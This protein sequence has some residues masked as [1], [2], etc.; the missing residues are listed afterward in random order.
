MNPCFLQHWNPDIS[1]PVYKAGASVEVKAETPKKRKEKDQALPEVPF[2]PDKTTH[3]EVWKLIDEKY[4]HSPYQSLITSYVEGLLPKAPEG[5]REA[6]VQNSSQ[7]YMKFYEKAKVTFM[8]EAEALKEK[9]DDAVDDIKDRVSDDLKVL[10]SA[11]EGAKKQTEFTAVMPGPESKDA[12]EDHFEDYL[13]ALNARYFNVD[14]NFGTDVTEIPV[15]IVGAMVPKGLSA[16]AYRNKANEFESKMS[17]WVEAKLEWMLKSKKTTKQDLDEFK[18]EIED[19]YKSYSNFDKNSA[20]ISGADLVALD[21]LAHPGLDDV[22]LVLDES[23]EG[24]I[25]RLKI[26]QLMN[27]DGWEETVDMA[28]D[29]TLKGVLN[30]HSETKFIE[31]MKQ[32]GEVK[33]FGDAADLFEDRLE[34]LGKADVGATLEFIRHFNQEVHGD[35]LQYEAAVEPPALTMQV[36]KQMDY[37]LGGALVPQKQEDRAIVSFMKAEKEGRDQILSNPGTRA[38][39]FRAIKMA[40]EHY[41]T[42][43]ETQFGN[44]PDDVSKLRRSRRIEKPTFHDRAAQLQALIILGNQA[45]VIVSKFEQT[46]EHKGKGYVGQIDDAQIPDE[47]KMVKLGVRF[48]SAGSKPAR[49]TSGLARGGFNTRDLALKGVKVLGVLTVVSNVA[50]SWSETSGDLPDRLLDTVERSVT[51]HGVLAGAA[52]TAGSH[53]AERNKAF[54]RYPWLSQH[55]RAGAMAAF[56]L[57]NLGRRLGHDEV[58]RFTNNNAEWR[59]LKD[60]AM[61]PSQIKEMLKAAGKRVKGKQKPVITINDLKE[62]IKDESVISTLTKGGRSARMRYMFYQKFFAS[63][64]KPDVN[65]VK[66]LC[67]GSSYIAGSPAKQK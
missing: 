53:M 44:I 16:A 64:S 42:M 17:D 13:E 36:H 32:Y 59:A 25:R 35:L 9:F 19:R 18:K 65:H 15:P 39:L 31:M 7:R 49:Y 51:S 45:K 57:D 4:G 27:P 37:L 40:T 30:N 21:K 6:L 63:P 67:T 60:P 48:H 8:T 12:V 55:E 38:V 46:P 61:D 11:V 33:D 41:P 47:T 22:G 52:M 56:K 29:V 50:Q 24:G 3:D 34:E 10:K 28:R 66:E 20:I 1:R 26:M 14:V 54:L 2:D 43:Y 62:V 58:K 23:G 5:Y